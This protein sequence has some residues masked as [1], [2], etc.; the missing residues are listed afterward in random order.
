MNTEPNRD[1]IMNLD[2][3]FS[4]LVCRALNI[5]KGNHMAACALLG[6]SERTIFRYRGWYSIRKEDSGEWAAR[7][8]WA[9]FEGVEKSVDKNTPE[10]IGSMAN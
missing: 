4:K 8:F 9:V 5:T 2:Y 1:E 6:I 7:S 10:E 3:N